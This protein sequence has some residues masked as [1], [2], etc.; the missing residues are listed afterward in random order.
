MEIG[1]AG[2]SVMEG[3]YHSS[4]TVATSV[5]YVSREAAS[6][7]LGIRGQMFPCPVST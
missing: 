7:L 4:A 3:D 1:E 5:S 6:G 2:I